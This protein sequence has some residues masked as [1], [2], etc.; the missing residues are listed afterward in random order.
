MIIFICGSS[1]NFFL[2]P[3]SEVGVAMTDS[4]YQP[5]E[6]LLQSYRQIFISFESLLLAVGAIVFDKNPV[7][8]VLISLIG[9]GTIWG[10][11]YRIVRSRHL[12][13]DYHKFSMMDFMPVGHNTE[14]DYVHDPKI[15]K[16]AI[17]AYEQ[18]HA[19]KKKVHNGFRPTRVK[20]DLVL[21]ILLTIVWVVLWIF[22]F[23]NCLVSPQ[24][25][26]QVHA[27]LGLLRSLLP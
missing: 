20:L 9:I 2:N 26:L 4:K 18:E 22:S 5:N 12:I 25:F 17:E 7:V 23:Y 10:M 15:R 13:V 6:D 21:P 19:E 14:D 16:S 1:R 24:C 27:W 8:M 3:L 11:W